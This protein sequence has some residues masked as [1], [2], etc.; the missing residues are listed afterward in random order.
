MVSGQQAG[1]FPLAADHPAKASDADAW[2]TSKQ[3]G[4]KWLAPMVLSRVH[5]LVLARLRA[6]HGPVTGG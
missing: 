1:A 6:A 3:P 4:P 2:P 5:A